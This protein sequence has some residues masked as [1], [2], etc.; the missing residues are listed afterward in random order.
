[1]TV[2]A[3]RTIRD[4]TRGF[5][6]WK[7]IEPITVPGVI[8]DIDY[9]LWPGGIVPAEGGAGASNQPP[10]P[11][12]V[13]IQN[14]KV[15]CAWVPNMMMRAVGKRVPIAQFQSAYYDGGIA[16]YWGSASYPQIGAGYYAGYAEPFDME[17]ALKWAYDDRAPVLLGW[18]Y[19]NSGAL[20]QGHV[21]VLFPSGWVLES[22][23]GVGLRWVRLENSPLRFYYTLM[24]RGYNWINY[25]GDEF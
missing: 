9:Y 19:V 1:M 15:F 20:N 22:A 11:I 16:A 21:S 25:R 2:T 23:Y 13:Y 7:Y 3:M 8:E 10:K 12:G 18:R 14:G 17:T 6:A 5:A 4:G 24:V